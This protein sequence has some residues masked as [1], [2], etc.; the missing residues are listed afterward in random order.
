MSTPS[1]T[2]VESL[3][4]QAQFAKIPE[5][6]ASRLA[7]ITRARRKYSH[8]LDAGRKR[9]RSSTGVMSRD[10]RPETRRFWPGTFVERASRTANLVLLCAL[11]VMAQGIDPA[12]TN[13]N[14]YASAPPQAAALED[15]CRVLQARFC[16]PFLCPHLLSCADVDGV[17]GKTLSC[18]NFFFGH[19]SLHPKR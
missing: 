7:C 19:V 9:L 1:P 6:P 12:H 14:L 16:P 4:Q 3:Q 13:W 2:W 5:G 11:D 15:G 8:H 17:V 18:C 10:T